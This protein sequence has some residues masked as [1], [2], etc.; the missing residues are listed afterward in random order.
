[1][2]NCGLENDTAWA[3]GLGLDRLAMKLFNIPDIR[4]SWSLD[5]KITAQWSTLAAGTSSVSMVFEN[6]CV[7]DPIVHSLSFWLPQN[8]SCDGAIDSRENDFFDLVREVADD[9]VSD[10]EPYDTFVHPKTGRT[11]RG[12]RLKFLPPDAKMKNAA[13]F[14][15]LT[16]SYLTRIAKEAGEKLG[17]VQK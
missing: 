12:Y 15:E 13:E 9:H 7:L 2:K 1:M 5:E 4:I 17:F 16:V 6:R 11:A 8:T 3:F 10:I 14:K